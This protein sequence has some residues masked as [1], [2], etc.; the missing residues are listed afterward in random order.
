MIIKYDYIPELVKPWSE[1]RVEIK[2][3]TFFDNKRLLDKKNSY[4]YKD[5]YPQFLC[6]QGFDQATWRTMV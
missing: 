2:A 1:L 3:S 5:L 6:I 4:A